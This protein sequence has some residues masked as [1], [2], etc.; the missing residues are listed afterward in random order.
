MPK[1]FS[2]IEKDIQRNTLF[3]KGLQMIVERGYKNV[4]VDEAMKKCLEG[5][6]LEYEL[7]KGYFYR[8]FESKE[9]FFL[10][11]ISWQMTQNLE[12]LTAARS[13]GAST[14]ELSQLYKELFM[15]AS[16]INYM[17]MFYIYSKVSEVQ[18]KQFRDFEESHYIR[19]VKLLG[20]DPTICD[21][22]V[23]S[24]LSAMIYLSC[25]MIQYAPYLFEEKNDAVLDILLA[26][27]H[28]YV[29]E[30]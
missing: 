9:E 13:N 6:G 26:T 8:L 2:D 5:T 16:T 19:V 17:D 20:K 1:I 14:D 21:P 28:R 27:M 12:I 3:E 25:G 23:L 15:Q 11:A 30:H 22:K 7:T 24:N 4:T 10:Q 29:T 18:W